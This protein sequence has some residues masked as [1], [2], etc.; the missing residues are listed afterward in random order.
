[1][2]NHEERNNETEQGSYWPKGADPPQ[3]PHCVHPL[4][5]EALEQRVAVGLLGYC[6]QIYVVQQ[7]EHLAGRMDPVLPHSEPEESEKSTNNA[8]LSNPNFDK[9][10]Y[11]GSS[12]PASRPSKWSFGGDSL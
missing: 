12:G 11:P 7:L 6:S 10:F 5:E 4:L 3:G 2:L 8:L 1:M 9:Q